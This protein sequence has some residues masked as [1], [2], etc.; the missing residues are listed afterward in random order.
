MMKKEGNVPKEEGSF[1]KV[2]NERIRGRCNFR[3]IWD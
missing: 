2:E 3:K 1:E